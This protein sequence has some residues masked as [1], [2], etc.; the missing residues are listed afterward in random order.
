MNYQL[1]TILIE[2]P[3]YMIDKY[4][5]DFKDL[6]GSKHRDSVYMLRE[7]IDEIM[8]VVYDNPDMLENPLYKQDYIKAIAMKEALLKHGVYYDA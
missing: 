7:S 8:D 2:V 5:E 3:A 4:V 6:A 1:D